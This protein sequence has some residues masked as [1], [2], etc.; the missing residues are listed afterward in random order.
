[1][2]EPAFGS[3]P[4]FASNG[5]LDLSV[6]PDKQ[7]FTITCSD[8]EVIADAGGP[9]PIATRV[10]SVVIPAEG[11]DDGV[12][13]SFR[14]SGFAFVTEGAAGL[15]MIIV[16]GDAGIEHLRPG[17]DNEFMQELTVDG[18]GASEC[19]LSVVLIAERDSGKPD[20]IARLNILSIDG[21]I[22]R[23]AGQ[24]MPATGM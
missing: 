17:T 12:E 10:V 13:I 6:S 21:E 16:N 23:R 24:K 20:A 18:S 9:A 3:K 5:G 7:A 22:S 14:A 15:A 8:V 1:M 4:T 19:R 11:L 2:S